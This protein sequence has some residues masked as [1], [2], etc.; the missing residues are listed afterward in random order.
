[1]NKYA[2]YIL[3]LLISILVV[4]LFIND[5]GPMQ[6]LQRSLDDLLCGIT[7]VD[8]PRPGVAI[9]R[10]DNQAIKTFGKWPWNRDLIADLTA[11]VA[12][13]EPKAVVLDFELSEDASQ[14]SAGFTGI[15]AD[16]LNWIQQAVLPYDI[17]M[18]TF[19]SNKTSNPPQ[20]FRNSVAVNN[21]LGLMDEKGQPHCLESVSAGRQAGCP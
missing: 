14:D 2:S 1:M 3:Y 20:L 11:A 6:R 12:S 4:I 18:A 10:I 15:L 19:R 7:A 13:A 9:V 21:R 16:Q 8:G 5:F 17:T